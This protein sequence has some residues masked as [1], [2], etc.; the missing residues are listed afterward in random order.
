MFHHRSATPAGIADNGEVR[1]LGNNVTSI[2]PPWG[3]SAL[4]PP[5]GQ[6]EFQVNLK[7]GLTPHACTATMHC[8]HDRDSYA[9]SDPAC[10]YNS[11][12]PPR[13]LN[14]LC[15]PRPLWKLPDRFPSVRSRGKHLDGLFA[16]MD[17]PNAAARLPGAG[18]EVGRRLPFPHRDHAGWPTES[19]TE[20]LQTMAAWQTIGAWREPVPAALHSY[21]FRG[22]AV[23][24]RGQIGL[25]RRPRIGIQ[26]DHVPGRVILD[27]QVVFPDVLIQQRHVLQVESGLE[28]WRN[29]VEIAVQRQDSQINVEGHRCRQIACG[30]EDLEPVGVVA[31]PLGPCGI[32]MIEVPVLKGLVVQVGERRGRGKLELVVEVLVTQ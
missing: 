17:R 18:G 12:C 15:P 7:L 22:R 1:S 31:T 10:D 8:N 32:D 19:G 2:C 4:G 6:T 26:V 20:N 9:P 29:R 3:L 23:E 16:S 5:W 25:H 24:E 11:L 27:G 13:P 30:V 14:S 21:L 28:K